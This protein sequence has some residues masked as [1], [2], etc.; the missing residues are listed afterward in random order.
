MSIPF[1][2]LLALVFILVWGATSTL[3]WRM[4]R[5]K[6][7]SGSLTE[8]PPAIR[9]AE[10]WLADAQGK[11][12]QLVESAEQ[13]L[14]TAQNELL[15]LRLEAGRLPLG[16]K[17]L[18]SVRESLGGT[19]RP[20]G[21]GKDLGG[22][23][24][25]YLGE[26]GLRVEGP[27]LVYLAT[28]LGEMACLQVGEGPLDAAL[29]AALSRVSRAASG[30]LYFQDPARYRECL[31][32]P[33]WMEGIKVQRL[34]VLDPQGLSAILLSLKLSRDAENVVKVFQDGVDSTRALTGQS[35]RMGE[36]LS[37]LSA[38]SLKLRTLMDGSG[39]GP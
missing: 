25:L 17:N 37:R 14:S 29:K 33:Q 36:A 22:T 16:I 34:M 2:L 7:P 20:G 8:A 11:M 30:F 5:S 13:P 26:E 24:R 39:H 3:F 38:D 19:G 18:R 28:S 15:E 4:S 32:N 21:P 9:L 35:D 10:Q 27:D 31:G 1:I 6:G 12:Q 23:A